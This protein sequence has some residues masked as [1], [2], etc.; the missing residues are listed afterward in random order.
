MKKTILLLAVATLSLTSCTE[1]IFNEDSK[2][3]SNQ[4]GF[5][6]IIGKNQS[7]K[8]TELDL[9]GLK[10]S[11]FVVNAYSTN[12]SNTNVDGDTYYYN[13]AENLRVTW[14]ND[15][16][17]YAGNLYW[18]SGSSLTFF[19]VGGDDVTNWTAERPSFPSFDYTISTNPEEQK[20]LV[21]S[22]HANRGLGGEAELDFKHILTQINFE[23]K[24]QD[25]DFNYNV[26]K[27]EIIRVNGMGKYTYNS[28][29]GSWTP[30]NSGTE[31]TYFSN[32]TTPKVATGTNFTTFAT[33]TNALMLLP[34]NFEGPYMQNQDP[35]ILVTYN[36][37]NSQGQI[38][39]NEKV[40]N[41]PIPWESEWKIGTKINYKLTLPTSA[42]RISF[43]AEVSNWE[44]GTP[45]FPVYN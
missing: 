18:P 35:R 42:S 19:A 15:M 26:K 44:T 3:D 38:I 37:T 45:V 40:A 34:Q 13:F 17:N 16:W 36:V 22:I 1:E 4:I 27:I 2:T 11:G 31:Y 33:G 21:S 25:A 5:Q 12:N 9:N 14:E 24:G 29:K 32:N 8:A 20:D 23:I 43:S 39:E 41:A 30:I 10:T 28:G 7:T 6:T